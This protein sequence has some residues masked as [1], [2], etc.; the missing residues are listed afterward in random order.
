M[1]FALGQMVWWIGLAFELLKNKILPYIF[2][3]VLSSYLVVAQNLL[4]D[5]PIVIELK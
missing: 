5:G 3:Y 4:R 2:F 1:I